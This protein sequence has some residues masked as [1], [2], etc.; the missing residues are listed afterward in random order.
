MLTSLF[1]KALPPFVDGER[2]AILGS[3][4]SPMNYVWPLLLLLMA[5]ERPEFFGAKKDLT[6]EVNKLTAPPSFAPPLPIL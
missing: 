3:I 2:F 1:R 5:C 6:R 4:R